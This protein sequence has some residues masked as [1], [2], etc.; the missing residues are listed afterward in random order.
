M[1]MMMI[2]RGLNFSCSNSLFGAVG[3]TDVRCRVSR[4]RDACFSGVRAAASSSEKTERRT[5]G[6]LK[7]NY[8]RLRALEQGEGQ[9]TACLNYLV[10]RF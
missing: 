6:R 1:H 5:H 8:P 7:K 10:C 2:K 4:Y 3:M 9:N